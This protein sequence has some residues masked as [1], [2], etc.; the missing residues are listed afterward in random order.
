[1]TFKPDANRIRPC[2]GPCGRMTRPKN[3]PKADFP[4]AAVRANVDYCFPCWTKTKKE[5]V[6]DEQR[7][8]NA[9]K[10]EADEQRKLQEG[11]LARESYERERRERIAARARR[12][13]VAQLVN[14]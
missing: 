7:A 12:S 5:G 13:R 2:A 6:N 11:Q 3:V 10:R 9:A 8:A 14:R 4:E 1:M